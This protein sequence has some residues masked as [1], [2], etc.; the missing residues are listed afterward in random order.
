MK[1]EG[2]DTTHITF[3]D[4]ALTGVGQLTVLPNG[5]NRVITVSGANAHL[6]VNDIISART[7]ISAAKVMLCENQIEKEPALAALQMANDLGG[8]I[9]KFVDKKMIEKDQNQII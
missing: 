5:K 3:T 6:T 7:T 9:R 2:V 1:T 8:I 4:D